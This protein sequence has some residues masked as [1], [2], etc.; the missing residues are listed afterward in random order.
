MVKPLGL[1][2][3]LSNLTNMPTF[4][5]H[6]NGMLHGVGFSAH[7]HRLAQVH[8]VSGILQI[9][10]SG[11]QVYFTAN[12]TL[13]EVFT[14][15]IV[16]QHPPHAIIRTYELEKLEEEVYFE[17]FITD[18]S[19][20]YAHNGTG[21]IT[22]DFS[23]CNNCRQE[24]SQPNHPLYQSPFIQCSQCGYR[25]AIQLYAPFQLNNTTWTHIEPGTYAKKAIG[26]SLN[27]RFEDS[28]FV[29]L[30][31]SLHLKLINSEGYTVSQNTN[32]I[33]SISK[34]LLSQGN[35]LTVKATGG[36]VLICDA[37]QEDSIRLLRERKKSSLQ[38]LHLMYSDLEMAH[39][40]IR[41]RP[42]EI[43]ALKN[44]AGFAVLCTPHTSTPLP[45]E[46]IT[47]VVHKAAVVLPYTG[48]LHIITEQFGRPLV[49]TPA[50]KQG[51]PALY[52]ENESIQELFELADYVITHPLEV[53]FGQHD[54]IVQFTE[55]EQK[56]ILRRARGM[57]PLFEPSPF[58]IGNETWLALGES[59]ESAYSIAKEKSY[60]VYEKQGNQELIPS[61]KKLVHHLQLQ[62]NILQSSPSVILTSTGYKPAHVLNLFDNA[63]VVEVPHQQAHFYSVLAENDLLFH[64]EPVLGIIWDDAFQG[65]DGMLG[66][67]DIFIYEQQEME[68]V[69]H[70]GR[71][72]V[73]TNGGM[74]Q[75][76]LSA[77]GI[78][79]SMPN[80]MHWERRHFSDSEWQAYLHQLENADLIETSS[81][82]QLLEGIAS[83]FGLAQ[84]N[85]HRGHA[86]LQLEQLA[87]TCTYPV[88]DYYRLPLENGQLNLKSFLIE[89]MEDWQQK[90]EINVIAWKVFF[91]LAKVVEKL[92]NHYYIDHIAF[93]GTVFKSS[94]LTDMIIEQLKHKRKLYFHKQVCSGSE[95]ISIGQMAYYYCLQ[96]RT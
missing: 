76:R 18:Y 77:L 92:S 39:S 22:P 14:Q 6:I 90:E 21:L 51:Y 32:D 79:K 81:I 74:Y 61:Q 63:K 68:R 3:L 48:L 24:M 7:V 80:K 5:F 62:L 93:S 86:L 50:E 12:D 56:I 1:I 10:I 87:Y 23:L 67:G 85:A 28:F 69:A 13:A 72:P 89:L 83:L 52:S 38:P 57:A 20:D 46:L 91:S 94:L 84:V 58:D 42:I 82:Q 31:D 8:K 71:F 2:I 19:K 60:F 16:K 37:A 41:L 78:L 44:R 73:L 33:L 55:R 15:Q 4:R 95:C 25:Y 70:L 64:P 27:R 47:P 45:F 30:S 35:I 54:S 40:D 65:D 88:Y 59:A 36:F 96:P 26:D 43:S 75:P 49:I 29:A 34:M 9:A 66:G 11:Y 53:A 17:G